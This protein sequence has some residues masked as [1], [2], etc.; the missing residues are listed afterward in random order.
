MVEFN[1]AGRAVERPIPH[2]LRVRSTHAAGLGRFAHR[3]L[4]ITCISSAYSAGGTTLLL[5]LLLFRIAAVLAAPPKN[6][7]QHQLKIEPRR[8]IACGVAIRS[9]EPDR[10]HVGLSARLR[11][12]LSGAARAAELRRVADVQLFR[13]SAEHAYSRVA[14]KPAGPLR[15]PGI[16]AGTFVEPQGPKRFS[17]GDAVARDRPD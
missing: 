14:R 1:D 8:P 16:L 3:D 10:H 7:S 13:T 2:L 6:S 15:P 17:G 11:P 4:E 12:G 9:G 5:D